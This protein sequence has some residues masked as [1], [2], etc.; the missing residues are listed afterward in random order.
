MRN[1]VM[2][3]FG[4]PKLENDHSTYEQDAPCVSGPTK[5]KVIIGIVVV[6]IFII[7]IA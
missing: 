6:A 5:V 7:C 2:L 3:D 1:L 4:A